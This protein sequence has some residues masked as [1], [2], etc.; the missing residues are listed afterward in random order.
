[1]NDMNKV[2]SLSI[3][4]IFNFVNIDFNKSW[5]FVKWLQRDWDP[6]QYSS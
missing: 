1:M 6:Q 5:H 3:G 4:K 2:S